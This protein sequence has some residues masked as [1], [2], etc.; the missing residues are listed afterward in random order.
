MNSAHARANLSS[1]EILWY[2]GKSCTSVGT[3]HIIGQL[4][5]YPFRTSA[6]FFKS[7]R[8][9]FFVL[10]DSSGTLLP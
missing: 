1:I 9:L 3:V 8:L 2:L 5:E 4:L 6:C 7:K 10:R